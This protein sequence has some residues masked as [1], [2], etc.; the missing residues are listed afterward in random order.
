M[1]RAACGVHSVPKHG[2]RVIELPLDV[3]PLNVTGNTR[4]VVCRVSFSA[5]AAAASA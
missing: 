4:A 5:N 3:A 1:P 2:R